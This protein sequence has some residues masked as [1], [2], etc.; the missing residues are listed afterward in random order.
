MKCTV[1][2]ITVRKTVPPRA[3]TCAGCGKTLCPKHAH[4]YVDGNNAAITDSARPECA[5]CKGMVTIHCFWRACDHLVEH[6]DPL[7]GSR[8]M[9]AHYEAKH[10]ADL[11]TLGYPAKDGAHG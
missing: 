4:Y 8:I 11:V 3:H 6:R 9:Q 7:Q 2:D 1:C 5:T 10:D